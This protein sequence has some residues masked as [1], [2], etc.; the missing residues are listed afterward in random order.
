MP[1][2]IQTCACRISQH[3]MTGL[4]DRKELMYNLFVASNQELSCQ[5]APTSGSFKYTY[6]S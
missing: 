4:L 2:R 1:P 6:R 3:K 5:A